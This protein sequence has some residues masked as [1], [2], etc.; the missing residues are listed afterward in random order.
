MPRAGT[1]HSSLIGILV[2]GSR[3]HFLENL[4]CRGEITELCVLLQ[5]SRRSELSIGNE[6]K[7]RTSVLRG[8]AST[9]STKLLKM[10]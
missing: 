2:H 10:E 7:D 1:H 8:T 4:L 3:G 5:I 6:S 9:G